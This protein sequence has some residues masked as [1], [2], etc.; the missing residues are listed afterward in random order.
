MT[1]M[2]QRIPASLCVSFHLQE[3]P[4]TIAQAPKGAG[5]VE[6][7]SK[8]LQPFRREQEHYFTV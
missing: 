6:A 3:V 5:K 1:L 4:F 7:E 8:V 2:L